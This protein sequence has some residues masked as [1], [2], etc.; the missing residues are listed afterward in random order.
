MS[1]PGGLILVGGAG[2]GLFGASNAPIGLGDQI[3]GTFTAGGKFSI[4]GETGISSAFITA[5]SPRSYDGLLGYIIYAANEETRASRTRAGLGASD[6]SN[7]PS[8]N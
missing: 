6:D 1:V 2:S 4:V 5:N 7:S 8:C 3:K